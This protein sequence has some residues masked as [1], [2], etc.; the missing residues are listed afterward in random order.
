MR[1]GSLYKRNINLAKPQPDKKLVVTWETFRDKLVPGQ[2]EEWKL[3][4]EDKDGKPVSASMLASAYDASLDELYAHSWHFGLYFRRNI[5]Y[6]YVQT[7]RVADNSYINVKYD[8]VNA[9]NG[10]DC[11]YGNKFT[12]FIPFSWNYYGSRGMIMTKSAS[13]GLLFGKVMSSDVAMNSVNRKSMEEVA[14]MSPAMPEMENAVSAGGQG[15]TV[16]GFS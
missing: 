2:K 11:I 15:R 14:D 7:L 3:K 10:I 12:Q 1:K 6:V 16:P 5:P 8:H 13:N 9:G 4:V